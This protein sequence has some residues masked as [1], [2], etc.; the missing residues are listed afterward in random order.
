MGGS[1]C[2]NREAWEPGSQAGGKPFLQ[3]LAHRVKKL[4]PALVTPNTHAASIKL[5]PA[6]ERVG[7]PESLAI[8]TKAIP[9]AKTVSSVENPRHGATRIAEASSSLRKSRSSDAQAFRCLR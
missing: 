8:K 2:R 6:H 4:T 5:G 9:S 3:S 1:V 7:M